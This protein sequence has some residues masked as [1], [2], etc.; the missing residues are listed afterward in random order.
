MKKLPVAKHLSNEDYRTLLIAYAEHNSSMGRE[1]SKNYTLSD[2]V[3]VEKNDDNQ[4]LNVHY[5]DGKS[6]IYMAW[7]LIQLKEVLC[8]GGHRRNN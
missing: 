1:E 5:K 3:K 8:F 6:W 4:W 2:I 7:F